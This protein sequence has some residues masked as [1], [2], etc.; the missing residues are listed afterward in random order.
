MSEYTFDKQTSFLIRQKAAE[1]GLEAEDVLYKIY[2]PVQS[3]YVCAYNAI[4][5][6]VPMSL[7]EKT[8]PLVVSLMIDSR[9]PEEFNVEQVWELFRVA[10]SNY[11]KSKMPLYSYS[12][13]IVQDIPKVANNL[14]KR[15][16]VSFDERKRQHGLNVV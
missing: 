9:T 13:K 14:N 15:R 8:D 3:Y 16:L 12:C 2:Q 1:D 5:C 7:A 4:V 6:M 10:V 11:A